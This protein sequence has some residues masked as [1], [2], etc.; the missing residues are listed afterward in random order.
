MSTEHLPT[1]HQPN[2]DLRQQLL[3]LVYDLLP[4]DEAA[5]LRQ[6]IAAEPDVFAAFTKAQ[7]TAGLLAEAVRA[8]VEPIRLEAPKANSAP[9]FRRGPSVKKKRPAVSPLPKRTVSKPAIRWAVALAASL[10]AVVALGGYLFEMWGRNQLEARHVR[11]IVAGPQKLEPG[12]DNLFT[13][14]VSTP[15]GRPAATEVGYRLWTPDGK[16]LVQ[17]MERTDDQG[18]LTFKLRPAPGATAGATARLDVLAGTDADRV[19]MHKTLPV[20]PDRLATHVSLD[21][22]LYQPGETIYYR[23]LTLSRFGLNSSPQ[24]GVLFQIL[25]PSGAVVSGSQTQQTTELGVASGEFKIPA[26]LSGGQYSL[27]ARSLNDSFADDKR[28]FFVRRYRLPRLKKDLEF[29]RDS[30]VPGD[31]VTADLSV[32][33][34]EGGPAAGANLRIIATVD[35]QVAWQ[36]TTK[37][38]PSGIFQVDF[39]LPAKIDRGD[40]QLAV[41]IDDGGTQETLAKTI[42]I[43]LG[44][45]EV[46]FYPEGGDLIGGLENRVYFTGR[47]PLGKPVH[48]EGVIVDGAGREVARVE[49]SHKGMGRFSLTP[50]M[51]ETYSLKISK[52]TGISDHPSLPVVNLERHVVLSTGTGVFGPQEPLRAELLSDRD[53][54]P[55]VLAAYCRGVLVGQQLVSAHKGS[56]SVEIP[57]SADVGGVVRLTVFER[58]DVGQASSPDWNKV[59]RDRLGSLSYK[60]SGAQPIA[61]RL[62]YRRPARILNVKVEEHSDRYAPGDPVKLSLLVT[63]EVGKPTPAVLG[64]SVVDDA[65]FKLLDDETPK[66]TTHFYLTSEIE[67][68]EDLEKADFYLSDEKDA[69]AS[70]DLLLG[71]QGWRRFAEQKIEVAA[72]PNERKELARAVAMNGVGGAPVL[73]DNQGEAHAGYQAELLR[74]NATGFDRWVLLGKMYLVFAVVAILCW[75]GVAS[76]RSASM[77]RHW[78]LGVATAGACLFFVWLFSPNPPAAQQANKKKPVQVAMKETDSDALR[79]KV[80]TKSVEPHEP[81]ADIAIQEE[82]ETLLLGTQMVVGIEETGL[83]QPM[84]NRGLDFRQG[85]FQASAFPNSL[86]HLMQREDVEPASGGRSARHGGSPLV[87]VQVLARPD[88]T[89]SPFSSS[90]SPTTVGQQFD[91]I[92]VSTLAPAGTINANAQP[93]HYDTWSQNY[94]N[95]TALVSDTTTLTFSGS[96]TGANTIGGVLADSGFGRQAVVGGEGTWTL[97]GTNAY[98]GG[99]T[100]T[101]G[102][103]GRNATFTSGV[104]TSGYGYSPSGA[105]ARRG[106]RSDF[107]SL[108]DLITSTIKPTSWD[109]AGGVGTA[110][111]LPP[112]NAVSNYRVPGLLNINTVTSLEVWN[113]HLN[114][115]QH[116]T[117]LELVVSQTDRTN[118]ASRFWDEPNWNGAATAG[119]HVTGT[120]QQTGTI[121]GAAGSMNTFGPALSYVINGGEFSGSSSGIFGGIDS[122]DWRASGAIRWRSRNQNEIADNFPINP[123]LPP[124]GTSLISDVVRLNLNDQTQGQMLDDFERLRQLRIQQ[125]SANS[126]SPFALEMAYDSSASQTNHPGMVVVGMIDG[127][128]RMYID[129]IDP[130]VYQSLVTR[131]GGDDWTGKLD[132][133]T[134]M[135]VVGIAGGPPYGFSATIA[136]TNYKACIDRL[137]IDLW[138][139]K[140]DIG[141]NGLVI[142]YGNGADPFAS[143]TNRVDSGF[144]YGTWTGTGITSSLA[145]AAASSNVPLNI[146]LR[147]FVPGGAGFGS[148]IKFG[149]QPID[150]RVDYA[151]NGISFN[152]YF[153]NAAADSSNDSPFGSAHDDGFNMVF[154]DGS[155]P[156]LSYSIDPQTLTLLGSR[157][158]GQPIDSA[159]V[160]GSALFGDVANGSGA[161]L[162]SRIVPH[163]LLGKSSGPIE[164]TV[165]T[166]VQGQNNSLDR[167]TVSMAWR[168]RNLNESPVNNSGDGVG[169]VLYSLFPSEDD[170]GPA[171]VA[172][173]AILEL[174]GSVSKLR[175]APSRFNGQSTEPPA[176]S[177]LVVIESLDASRFDR[178]RSNGYWHSSDLTLSHAA[179]LQA[180]YIGRQ[181]AH[182][183]LESGPGERADFSETLYWHPL[184]IAGTDGR[185]KIAFD[186]SDS[187]TTFRVLADA[188]S[189]T[190]HAGQ[191]RIGT[192]SGEVVARMPFSL[193]P[194]LPLEVNAGDRID[195][196]VAVVNDTKNEMQVTVGLDVASAGDARSS[197]GFQPPS[198]DP[199]TAG[200]TAAGSR[201]YSANLL[202]L[203][204]DSSRKLTLAADARMRTYFPLT[205]VGD[206]GLAEVQVHGLAG[207]LSDAK[208]Q[209]VQVVPTGYPRSGSYAGRLSGVQPLTVRIPKDAVPGSLAVSLTAFPSPMADLQKGLKSIFEEPHG[210]FEQVSTSTYPNVMALEFLEEHKLADPELTRR[211]KEL[212][213]TGYGMLKGYECRNGGFEWF[214]ADPGHTALTAYGLMEFRDMARVYPVDEAMIERTAKWLLDRRD[215]EGGF[216]QRNAGYHELG[217]S[218]PDV[219]N[220][221]IVWALTESGQADIEREV[222]HAIELGRKSDDPYLI[223]LAAGAALNGRR[224]SDGRELL[225][226]LVKLQGADG[227]LTGRAESISRSGGLSL[228]TETTALAA[229]AWFKVPAYHS[230]AERAIDWIV[231]NRQGSGGFGST[232][233]TILALK[234]LIEYARAYHPS[235]TG[236]EITIERAGHAIGRATFDPGEQREIRIEGLADKLEPGTNELTLRLSGE[237]RMPY[238]LDISYRGPT[239]LSD[240][241]CPVRLTTRLSAAKVR[242][243]ET[244]ALAAELINTTQREQPM[245]MAIIGLPA[246]LQARTTQLEDLKKAGTIDYYETRAREVICYWRALAPGQ[247]IP[248]SLDLVAEW[249]GQY[250]GPASC[251]YLYYTAEQKQWAEPLK[252]EIGRE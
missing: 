102:M 8:P 152:V 159:S 161:S 222:L 126:A 109:N 19:W 38:T 46:V 218:P 181:Y 77:L 246:G 114:G 244:V 57:L 212:I 150:T 11:M 92:V 230:H 196:P 95:V 62:V 134:G 241:A 88:G 72:G 190:T 106:E 223:A 101:S 207:Q 74:Y 251:A 115:M 216:S 25:D 184:L 206:A 232:Q 107:D 87:Y 82:E 217:A 61:E 167:D 97:N 89:D 191:G 239:G 211:A 40:G 94:P 177:R 140:L 144:S 75:A 147:D 96:N 67:K 169:A 237:A 50:R 68:P 127:S 247:R 9:V 130:T 189:A 48:V 225:D 15:S 118:R 108:I 219:T 248:L 116:P 148:S 226:K 41:V 79:E 63:N 54:Q 4:D 100:I 139:G 157:N 170:R 47:D 182:Q 193:E 123:P 197:G 36:N 186:L 28:T 205:V 81:N 145:R 238:V 151:A 42:P 155:V 120:N 199:S 221:Y 34:A 113:A 164:H 202:R 122:P 231:K 215:G 71:T 242:A 245:T 37:T 187:V 243:G 141:N 21:K 84:T 194:K 23:S 39:K 58:S 174:S 171:T 60:D 173:G 112:F 188:H 3:E 31:R 200:A 176:S 214:G 98:S 154:C 73:F 5:A 131:S 178:D 229:L 104:S 250:T 252:V 2:D 204:G 66:M 149:G 121:T 143:T 91:W 146:G 53:D 55:L 85:T 10:L 29:T 14:A 249:P 234:A 233:G 51:A 192:G 17:K 117:F 195:L 93:D 172:N 236:G 142:Q 137:D 162:A 129:S 65:I 168:T 183:H 80:W 18:R 78:A 103:L 160:F 235:S 124:N 210:C 83:F 220:V 69:P 1:E 208:R 166:I 132:I 6:R 185:A 163:S 228:Q 70:L 64:V 56:N 44:R 52:P 111:F 135:D 180:R 201:R 125:F 99:T 32:K 76:Y 224:A 203:S 179:K 227:Q 27:V 30:Y 153:A 110:T 22:P 136:P 33:R 45:L 240:P 133:G 24:V 12:V 209:T 175:R 35:G 138:T 213:K 86:E 13:V 198:A 119:L 158:D 165:A 59:G 26:D 128:P 43:N 7:Q 20:E 16:P 105:D 49:T 156:K 90:T